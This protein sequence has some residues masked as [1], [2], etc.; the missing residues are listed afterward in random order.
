[1][2]KKILLS[3]A[4]PDC[5][6]MMDWAQKKLEAIGTQVE[7]IDIGS[8]TLPDGKSLKLPNV[9]FGVLG[10]VSRLNFDLI[11]TPD[12][13]PQKYFMIYKC[14]VLILSLKYL[15]TCLDKFSL[16]YCYP[17]A[18]ALICVR[19]DCSISTFNNT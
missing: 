4:R 8:Q 6:R 5:Q 11:Q 10:N 16:I 12:N 17:I 18:E 19:S 9:I 7:Q 2:N 15:N 3:D 14:F 1:M 13:K